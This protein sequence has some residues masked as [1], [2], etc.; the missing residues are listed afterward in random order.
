MEWFKITI[1]SFSFTG[2]KAMK[3]TT[4]NTQ[5]LCKKS[6]LPEKMKIDFF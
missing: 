3:I 1:S 4:S 5:T 2:G 6:S